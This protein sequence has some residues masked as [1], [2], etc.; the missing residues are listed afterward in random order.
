MKTQLDHRGI[1]LQRQLS[2]LFDQKKFKQ[3]LPIAI[4]LAEMF[5]E[6]PLTA[7]SVSV[8]YSATDQPDTAV[9]VLDEASKRFPNHHT[10]LFY[11][12]ESQYR[13]E[14][15]EEAEQTYRQALAATPPERKSER[16]A[17]YNGLGVVLW[18]QVM[19]D[20]ALA[21]WREAIKED[22]ANI[23]ARKNLE[24]FTNEF[25]EPDAPAAVFE[26][27][28]HFQRIQKERYLGNQGRKE[29]ESKEEME[30][31]LGAIFEAWNT[32]LA[33]RGK[34]IDS[35]TP[36]EK[37]ELFRSVKIDFDK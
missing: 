7:V 29:F 25:N 37:T 18:Y 31:V 9:K 35:M 5:P 10:I 11:L 24:E 1:K 32:H 33:P 8:C 36:A 30:L 34:E 15:F 4:R 13:L 19:R 17:C 28:Y 27:L 22:P 20:E 12:A 3:A 23:P 21:M 14:H 16:G 26:D 6:D 2:K